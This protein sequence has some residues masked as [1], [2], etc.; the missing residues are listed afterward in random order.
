GF[1]SRVMYLQEVLKG[2]G[3][4]LKNDI[5]FARTLK[6]Y[7]S[8]GVL[9]RDRLEQPPKLL[10]IA[11]KHI[12]EQINRIERRFCLEAERIERQRRYALNVRLPELED[13]LKDNFLNPP[14]QK[15]GETIKGVVYSQDKQAA[16][17]GSRI[18]RP[19]DKMGKISVVSISPDGVEFEKDGRRWTQKIGE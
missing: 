7:R 17:I 13:K 16:F 5:E 9:T 1:F 2:Y 6:N 8:T 3:I 12:D 4:D 11:Q 19:G 14:K 15:S 10:A 18:I